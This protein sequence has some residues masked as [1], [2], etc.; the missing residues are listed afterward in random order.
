ML[1]QVQLAR[2]G[3]CKNDK[4]ATEESD[5]GYWNLR[6]WRDFMDIIVKWRQ[7]SEPN[8]QVCTH[9]CAFIRASPPALAD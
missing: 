8:D 7:I 3:K 2:S 1:F 5:D 4:L 6:S 9:G